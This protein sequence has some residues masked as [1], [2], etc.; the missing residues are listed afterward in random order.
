MGDGVG[1]CGGRRGEPGRASGTLG[2]GA[3]AIS[4]WGDDS[5]VASR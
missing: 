2:D 1:R 3:A 4:A 5:G